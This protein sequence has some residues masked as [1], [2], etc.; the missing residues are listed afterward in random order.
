MLDAKTRPLLGGPI[1]RCR[2]L[3]CI[4]VARIHRL[5]PGASSAERYRQQQGESYPLH[6]TIFLSCQEVVI[7]L[8]IIID[9]RQ[10]DRTF[11]NSDWSLLLARLCSTDFSASCSPARDVA[12][13]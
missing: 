10:E 11:E 8:I 12:S 3:R 2:L 7:D 1:A 13:T 9:R 6:R 4:R 5:F